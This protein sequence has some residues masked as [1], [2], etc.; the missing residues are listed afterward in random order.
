MNVIRYGKRCARSIVQDTMEG[1]KS[2]LDHGRVSPD[3]C[4]NPYMLEVGNGR[5]NAIEAQKSFGAVSVIRRTLVGR[6][7]RKLHGSLDGN[8]RLF[9]R[10]RIALAKWNA[11]RALRKE[12]RKHPCIQKKQVPDVSICGV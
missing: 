8:G 12:M 10:K 2:P 4:N 11:F 1:S 3:S 7:V 9:R 5:L 6:K